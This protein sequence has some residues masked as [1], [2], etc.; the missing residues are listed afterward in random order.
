MFYDFQYASVCSKMYR[1]EALEGLYFRDTATE[2]IDFNMQ[3]FKR[4]D[5]FVVVPHNIY[6]Y[7]QRPDSILHPVN[8][9]PRYI[10][11]LNGWRNLYFDYF[12]D[13]TEENKSFILQRIYKL[14][15]S[16]FMQASDNPQIESI[17]NRL[18]QDTVKD[19]K[20]NKYISSVLKVACLTCIKHPLLYQY[21]KST[22]GIFY[23]LTH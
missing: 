16:R 18:V 9:A 13:D 5:E 23:R 15:I 12:D 20:A 11:E 17:I 14:I 22:Y 6:F 19:F 3:L 21:G 7:L 2:D 1:R 10:V 8:V 4:A